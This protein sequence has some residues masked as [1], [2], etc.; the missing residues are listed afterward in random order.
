MTDAPRVASRTRPRPSAPGA[1]D[2]GP[3]DDL[4]AVLDDTRSHRSTI[5]CIVLA[6]DRAS[7]IT[8]A[9]AALLTQTRVPDVIHV[10]VGDASDATV[11]IASDLSGPHELHTELGTQFTEVFVH[12]IGAE[13]GGRAGALNYGYFLVE[14]CDYLLSVDGDAVA[15]PRA[16]ERL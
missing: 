16:V 15:H 7:S 3:T 5:G 14:G 12:D 10:V 4:T 11:E 1:V 9:I 6:S 13:P 8:D 2:D